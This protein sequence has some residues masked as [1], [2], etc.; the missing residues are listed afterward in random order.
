MTAYEF[1]QCEN[2]DFLSDDELDAAHLSLDDDSDDE[3][4]DNQ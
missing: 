2:C 4:G 3:E 1:E